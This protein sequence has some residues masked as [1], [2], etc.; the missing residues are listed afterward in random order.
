MIDGNYLAYRAFYTVGHL[1]SDGEG[2]GVAFGFLRE[3]NVLKERFDA[4]RV[5]FCFDYGGPGRRSELSNVY[6][7]KKKEWTKEEADIY[8]DFRGQL[9]KLRTKILPALGYRNVFVQRGYEADDIIAKLVPEFSKPEPFFLVQVIIVSA[10]RDLLQLLRENVVCYDPKSKKITTE[11]SFYLEWKMP[12]EMWHHVL[13]TAGC[14]S[15]NV[16]GIKG[17]GRI[18]AAKFHAGQLKQESFAYKKIKDNLQIH[19]DNLPL[20]KLPFPGT[21][22]PELRKDEVTKEKWDEVMGSLGFKTVRYQR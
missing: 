20:V 5:I 1:S 18:T 10:D 12:P 21:V 22:L 9:H 6:K 7:N 13:A 4:D 3:I 16:I 15:D 8:V 17:V 2:T 11:K 14:V 19:N